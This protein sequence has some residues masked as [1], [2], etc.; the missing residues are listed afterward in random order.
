MRQQHWAL[1]GAHATP[2]SD[3]PFPGHGSHFH[4]RCSVLVGCWVQAGVVEGEVSQLTNEPVL[5]C[6][7]AQGGAETWPAQPSFHSRKAHLDRPHWAREGLRPLSCWD[8]NVDKPCASPGQLSFL[9]CHT[10][11][12]PAPSTGS[13]ART[14]S[15]KGWFSRKE[16]NLLSLV[17]VG[18]C[19]DFSPLLFDPEQLRKAQRSDCPHFADGKSKAQR[20]SGFSN[21]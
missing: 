15:R 7:R 16:Q 3:P 4:H 8:G 1:K 10:Q 5:L 19:K 11:A 13:K 20:G 12:S 14:D 21:S 2:P 18:F 9:P 17:G 6:H